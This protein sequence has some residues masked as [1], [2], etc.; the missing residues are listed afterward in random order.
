MS[1]G[2]AAWLSGCTGSELQTSQ[3]KKLLILGGTNFLGPAIVELALLHGHELTL[4]NRGI[5][6]PVPL[7]KQAV[8]L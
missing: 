1:S 6:R 2:A 7:S 3:P 8:A 4:F 5:T